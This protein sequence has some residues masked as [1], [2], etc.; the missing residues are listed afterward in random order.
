MEVV[1]LGGPGGGSTL[2]V[3]GCIEGELDPLEVEDMQ[4]GDEERSFIRH[5]EAGEAVVAAEA[6][7]A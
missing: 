6:D 4:N 3:N 2:I 7:L 1:K 5:L